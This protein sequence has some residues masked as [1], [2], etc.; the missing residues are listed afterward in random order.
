MTRTQLKGTKKGEKVNYFSSHCIFFALKLLSV[1]KVATS[2]KSAFHFFS[3]S[4]S[5]FPEVWHEE[6][7]HHKVVPLHQKAH[8]RLA[9]RVL[10]QVERGPPL[11]RLLHD[12]VVD[13]V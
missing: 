6:P 10:R 2:L 8:H 12:P 4:E 1:R 9:A 13:V 11:V 5:P 3:L 7:P